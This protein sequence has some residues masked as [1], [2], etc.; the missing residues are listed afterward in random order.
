MREVTAFSTFQGKGYGRSR[1]L[2]VR[3]PYCKKMHI[4]PGGWADEKPD[5]GYRAPLCAPLSG[6]SLHIV[7]IVPKDKEVRR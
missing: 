1:M 2:H 3:C 7:G 6:P 4:Y 5:L